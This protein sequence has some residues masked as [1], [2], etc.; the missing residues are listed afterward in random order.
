MK[1]LLI[2]VML[3]ILAVFP[4]KGEDIVLT[5]QAALDLCSFPNLTEGIID[6]LYLSTDKFWHEGDYKKVFPVLKLIT[7]VKPSEVNAWALG[8]WFLINAVAPPLPEKEKNKVIEYAIK[9]SKEGI[10]NNPENSTLYMELAMHYFRTGDYE[11]AL[12]LL[13][14]GEKYTHS[15]HLLHLKA[16]IYRR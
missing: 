15:F 11:K 1:N 9:F 10:K 6:M 8:G 2:A 3:A 16:H 14:N 7:T 5:Q 13:E 4:A 12:P